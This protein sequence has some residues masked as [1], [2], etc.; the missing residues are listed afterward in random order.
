MG[1]K[2]VQAEASYIHEFNYPLLAGCPVEYS[3]KEKTFYYTEKV[4]LHV[5]LFVK[6]LDENDL[7]KVK[8]GKN[9]KIFYLSDY[10]GQTDENFT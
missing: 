2:A 4:K 10:I 3:R 5:D 1:Y 6:E 9:S 7:K 8:G